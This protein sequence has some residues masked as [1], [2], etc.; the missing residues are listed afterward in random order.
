MK[1]RLRLS[2]SGGRFSATK[3]DLIINK[4]GELADILIC[5]ANTGWEHDLRIEEQFGRVG[6]NKHG[7]LR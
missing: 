4:I 3:A 5:F 6:K 7:G 1:Q 2:F